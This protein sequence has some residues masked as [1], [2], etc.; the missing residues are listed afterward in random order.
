MKRFLPKQ[1]YTVPIEYDGT[2]AVKDP[3]WTYHKYIDYG[4]SLEPYGT[5][6][7]MA[8]F[9]EKAQLVNYNQYRALIEGFSAHMWDWYT[10]SII[11]KTQNPWTALRGQM[12]DY[13]L[14]PNACLFGLR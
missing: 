8:D 7:D 5:P 3:V 13:Y 6:E 1:N 2:E 11:W 12:Y 9:A 10:G 4:N 14:Y